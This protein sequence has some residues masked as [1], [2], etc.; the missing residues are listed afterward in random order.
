MRLCRCGTSHSG[1]PNQTEE[2]T[3]GNRS[4]AVEERDARD[5]SCTSVGGTSEPRAVDDQV[6]SN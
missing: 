3:M 1:K 2:P 5:N 6:A 4:A